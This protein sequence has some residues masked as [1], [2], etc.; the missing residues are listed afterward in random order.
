ME[1]DSVF[2]YGTLLPG[3]KNAGVAQRAGLVSATPA[4]VYGFRLYHL[5]PE[6]YPAVVRGPGI[7]HGSVLE[8]TGGLMALDELEG[9]DLQPPLYHRVRCQPDRSE[10]AWIYLYARPERLMEAGAA[11]VP[12][13]RWQSEHTFES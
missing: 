4:T 12:E 11:W 7:V 10:E 1:I 8:L 13:G 2:V 5:E 6:G 3:E 9:V